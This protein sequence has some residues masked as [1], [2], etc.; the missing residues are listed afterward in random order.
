MKTY[1]HEPAYPITP[2]RGGSE[3]NGLTKREEFAQ[4]A[5][6][7]LL[8]NPASSNAISYAEAYAEAAIRAADSLIA[9]LSQEDQGTHMGLCRRCGWDG[10]IK[11]SPRKR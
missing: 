3:S 5:L 6:Q 7:G 9:A 4:A 1:P 2:P 11:D 10:A 8:A